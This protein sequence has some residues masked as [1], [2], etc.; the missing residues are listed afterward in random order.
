MSL[1]LVSSLAI[2]IFASTLSLP[3]LGVLFKRRN[4]EEYSLSRYF[5]YELFPSNPFG[6]ALRV[7][8]AI[9]L[10]AGIAFHSYAIANLPSG[11]ERFLLIVSSMFQII[12]GFSIFFMALIPAGRYK[13]HLLC[14]VLSGVTMF[15]YDFLYA[16][17][18]IFG[19][20]M[21][22]TQAIPYV[23]AGA[24]I[25]IMA[26]LLFF[27]LNP[28]LR[29]WARLEEKVNEDGT[30]SLERPS[31]YWIAISEWGIIFLSSISLILGMFFTYL[32]SIGA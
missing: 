21:F 28:K 31:P 17:M 15:G 24:S 6:I 8:L 14:F 2:L 7:L 22:K 11:G 26:L 13:S 3:L 25:L 4:E 12:N 23:F 18:E 20:D 16:Y 30:T 27:F 29:N 19:A 9:P 1:S 5:P 32:M 10:L